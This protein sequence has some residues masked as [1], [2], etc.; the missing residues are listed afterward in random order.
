MVIYMGCEKKNSQE[1]ALLNFKRKR[2]TKEEK[3]KKQRNLRKQ[4]IEEGRY[5]K[6]LLKYRCINT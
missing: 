3:K 5:L 6:R 1:S 2:K 4:S